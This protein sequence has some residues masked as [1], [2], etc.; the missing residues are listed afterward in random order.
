MKL[1]CVFFRGK[2]KAYG[3]INTTKKECMCKTRE[4]QGQGY[5]D[6]GGDEGVR[7]KETPAGEG[8]TIAH[9]NIT[10]PELRKEMENHRGP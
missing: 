4:E 10:Q 6:G 7:M 9:H 5:I 1:C 3:V 8:E 2:V